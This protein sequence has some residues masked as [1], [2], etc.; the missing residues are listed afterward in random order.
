M[1]VMAPEDFNSSDNLCQVKSEQVQ[2]KLLY[3]GT[4]LGSHLTPAAISR[5]ART[6]RQ[7]TRLFLSGT[8]RRSQAVLGDVLSGDQIEHSA[9]RL[10]PSISGSMSSKAGYF[11]GA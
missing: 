8:D 2:M 7:P 6:R 9:G 5:H 11:S 1:A 3:R 10:E 4:G